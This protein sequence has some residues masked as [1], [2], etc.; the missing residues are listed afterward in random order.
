MKQKF[1]NTK[2]LAQMNEQEWESICDG[3]G[4][5]CLQKLQDDNTGEILYSRI[6]CKLLEL[7]TCRCTDYSKRHQRVPECVSLNPEETKYFKFLPSTCAYRL[8]DEGKPL[9]IWHPLRSGDSKS[10]HEQGIS[11][12][13]IAKKMEKNGIVE[14]ELIDLN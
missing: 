12:R 5:C 1:W 2:T 7:D 4:R 9:P 3:C 13:G 14:H 11:V 6:A 8:L 10:I